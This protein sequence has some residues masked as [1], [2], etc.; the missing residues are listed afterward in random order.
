MSE[1]S[2]VIPC[3]DDGWFLE[4]AVISAQRQTAPVEILI[5]DDGSADPFTLAL[6]DRLAA[7]PALRVL[8]APPRGLPQ[9]LNHAIEAA[10][11][12]YILPLGADDVIAP[13]YVERALAAFAGDPTLGI[14]YCRAE[15]FGLRGGPWALPDFSLPQMLLHNLIFATA[16][17]RRD[18]WRAVGGFDEALL[19]WEDYD[20]WLSLLELGRGV[21]RLDEVLF[22][23]RQR[24]TSMTQRYA[25][26]ERERA[27][28]HM[29]RKHEA[30]YRAHLPE[31]FARVRPR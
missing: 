21:H 27:F 6:L 20:F 23:Y 22:F 1:I 15:L 14:V 16:F 2:I 4:E 11:G 19:A 7:D 31:V 10:S 8:R 28:S 9:V 18:D 29:V 26:G 24:R 30:L 12:Q 25:P 13:R 5:A 17:F 3:R